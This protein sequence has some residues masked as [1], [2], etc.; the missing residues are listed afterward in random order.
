MVIH[1][2]RDTPWHAL[3]LHTF[4]VAAVDGLQHFQLIALLLS[5]IYIQNSE[6]QGTSGAASKQAAR[7][8]MEAHDGSFWWPVSNLALAAPTRPFAGVCAHTLA[9]GCC[10]T[11]TKV[12]IRQRF[13]VNEAMPGQGRDSL[14]DFRTVGR[15]C[16]LG[17]GHAA[18]W[19][20]QAYFLFACV[21]DML[22]CAQLRTRR[23]ITCSTSF[24]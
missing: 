15:T 13:V 6:I 1:A 3:S 19:V 22:S 4:Q 2:Q 17:V 9:M 21:R 20:T 12:R 24:C 5:I 8:P 23:L 11:K 7:I 18:V 14:Q 10:A 16:V